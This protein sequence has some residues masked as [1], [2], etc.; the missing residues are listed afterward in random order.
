M[1]PPPYALPR[2]GYIYPNLCAHLNVM[3]EQSS[4]AFQ[5]QKICSITT[6]LEQGIAVACDKQKNG[7]IFCFW[8]V[9][10]VLI[11]TFSKMMTQRGRR[12][13]VKAVYV[14]C[15]SGIADS[16]WLHARICRAGHSTVSSY[17][18]ASHSI[19][20]PVVGIVCHLSRGDKARITSG[21]RRLNCG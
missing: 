4:Y 12:K 8:F 18:L 11:K 20:L 17:V 5:W 1:R 9:P 10:V 15:I 3:C 2:F 21:K 16:R 6:L 14:E 13:I 7:N 19:W